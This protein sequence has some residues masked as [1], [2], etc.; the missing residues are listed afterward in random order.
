LALMALRSN[1]D[2]DGLSGQAAR[3]A[4]PRCGRSWLRSAAAL[5]AGGMVLAGI[6]AI[7]WAAVLPGERRVAPEDRAVSDDP[8]TAPPAD[9]RDAG[10]TAL[11]VDRRQGIVRIDTSG[12]EPDRLRLGAGF[13]V[14]PELVA[15]CRHVL[16]DAEHVRIGLHDG[17]SF[18]PRG[19][20]AV[21]ADDDL[22]L[23]RLPEPV[24]EALGLPLAERPVKRLAPVWAVGHPLGA[25][26]TVHS[27]QVRRLLR[28]SEL[29]E[30]SRAFLEAALAST[31]EHLWI[32]HSAGLSDGN[33]GGPLLDEAGQVV[34]VNVWVDDEAGLGYAL[35]VVHLRALL[36]A[37]G[38]GGSA[39]RRVPGA[40]E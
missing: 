9:P 5:V 4:Q 28:T 11:P 3:P 21:S 34:G 31:A 30:R 15:T 7:F 19:P 26:Y 38:L 39:S 16:A 2:A 8:T 12:R 27:G 22:A 17:R 6:A 23:L 20:A 32:E 37:S 14:S 40:D 18:E 13:F 29:P 33:S 35:D 24:P 10:A 36:D 1:R 25:E